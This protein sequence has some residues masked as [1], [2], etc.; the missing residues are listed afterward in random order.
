MRFRH[1]NLVFFKQ[2]RPPV[3]VYT[4]TQTG[5]Q[6]YS[7]YYGYS[8]PLLTKYSW[9]LVIAFRRLSGGFQE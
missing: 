2:Y 8:S 4:L 6:S 7:V 5:R 3:G 9:V 1:P